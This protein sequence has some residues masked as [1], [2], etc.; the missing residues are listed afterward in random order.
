MT[1][2]TVQNAAALSGRRKASHSSPDADLRRGLPHPHRAGN[3]AAFAAGTRRFF[4]RRQRRPTS[5]PVASKPRA[6]TT[7]SVSEPHEFLINKHTENH[8]RP[9]AH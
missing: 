2:R 3:R 9:P 4:H 5:S 1:D 8:I 6:S 7:S